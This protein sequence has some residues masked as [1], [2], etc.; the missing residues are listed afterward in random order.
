[1]PQITL[2]DAEA[3][4]FLDFL[5]RFSDNDTLAIK[6]PSEER[7]LWRIC[8]VLEKQV[9]EVFDPNYLQLLDN[10]RTLVADGEESR[11]ENK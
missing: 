8:G 7:V 3:L 1:V 11:G 9:V 10:A 5:S 2:S 4:V 6:H